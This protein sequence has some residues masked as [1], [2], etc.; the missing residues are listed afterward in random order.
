MWRRLVINSLVR[1]REAARRVLAVRVEADVLAQAAE[2]SSAS[3]S[4][5]ATSRS[6]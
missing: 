6:G 4:C 3:R 1:P 5:S 2:R